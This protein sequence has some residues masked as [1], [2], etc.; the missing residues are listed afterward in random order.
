M[1][2]QNIPN[3]NN[4][5][6]NSNSSTSAL[7][8]RTPLHV[9]RAKVFEDIANFRTLFELARDT[10]WLPIEFPPYGWFAMAAYHTDLYATVRAEIVPGIHAQHVR[11]IAWMLDEQEKRAD[12]EMGRSK[13]ATQSKQPESQQ[14][15]SEAS[16]STPAPVPIP[17]LNQSVH[18]PQLP[19]YAN[20]AA[21]PAAPTPAPAKASSPNPTAKTDTTRPHKT[22]PEVLANKG[23]WDAHGHWPPNTLVGPP[24]LERP[25]GRPP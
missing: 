19:S 2:S 13:A 9:T 8:A 12:A 7:P 14:L 23:G 1:S 5:S 22:W 10:P 6:N 17:R 24:A 18:A 20:Q 16:S 3:P 11:R 4:N 25:E 15:K 21:K